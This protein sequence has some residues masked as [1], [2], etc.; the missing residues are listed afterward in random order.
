MWVLNVLGTIISVD[1]LV[2][3]SKEMMIVARWGCNIH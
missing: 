2:M 3:E 1:L